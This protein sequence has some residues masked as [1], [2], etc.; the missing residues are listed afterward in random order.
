VTRYSL[1]ARFVLLLAAWVTPVSVAAQPAN[2]DWDNAQVL[3]EGSVAGTLAGATNDGSASVGT[4]GTPD[5]W[6]RYTAPA[7]RALYVDTCGTSDAGGI[8]SVLSVHSDAPG[9]GSNELT[10]NDDWPSGDD[11][12]GCEGVDGSPQLDSAVVLAAA[13]GQTIWIRVSEFNLASG[14]DGSFQ[15]NLPEPDVA[16]ALLPG[17]ALL[18]ALR[19]RRRR[20]DG[21]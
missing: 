18:G 2:D 10:A 1:F 13:P 9:T 4:P 5:V 19:A 11:P 12:T 3:G 17:L 16:I 14:G 6:Y 7:K 21:N 15:L 8:D 20:V